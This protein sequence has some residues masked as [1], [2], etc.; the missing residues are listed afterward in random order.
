MAGDP[1]GDESAA[2]H[3]WDVR[4]IVTN[5]RVN[6]R[7]SLEATSGKSRGFIKEVQAECFQ[8]F[9][10][11]EILTY[12]RNNWHNFFHIPFFPAFHR[13]GWLTRY[14][15]GP[16]SGALFESFFSDVWAGITVALTLIPQVS[17]SYDSLALF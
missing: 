5:A 9:E 12:I 14:I 1:V 11:N 3:N 7:T 13:P 15:V 4:S 16:H 17:K 6:I 2:A 8:T 10:V